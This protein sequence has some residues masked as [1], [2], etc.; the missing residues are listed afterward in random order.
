MKDMRHGYGAADYDR[1]VNS[2]STVSYGETD[3]EAYRRM[4]S[5]G[6]FGFFAEAE[7]G[8]LVG[9]LRILSDDLTK[10]YVCEICIHS[11]YQR[12]GVGRALLQHAIGR[13]S[14]TAI[15][16]ECFP[17]SVPLFSKCGVTPDPAYVGCSRAPLILPEA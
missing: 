11:D 2:V 17:N 8:F 1:V 7:V 9:F 16:A 15:W 12:R 14:H 10:S 5:R 3:H 13:F 4:F 6:V